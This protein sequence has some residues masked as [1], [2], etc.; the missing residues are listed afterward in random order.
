[1]RTKPDVDTFYSIDR[2]VTINLRV[3]EQEIQGA[4]KTSSSAQNVAFVSQSKSSTNKVKSGFTGAYSTC[5]PSTSSTNIFEKEVLASFADEMD[6]KL[7]LDLAKIAIRMKK[8]YK[9]TGGESSSRNEKHLG[10]T[11]GTS[12][13]HY[14]DPES[15]I[16]SVPPEVYVSTP[17]TTNE[18]ADAR[19]HDS[20]DM[21]TPTPA[22]GFACLIAKATS[23]ESKLWHRRLGHINF[24]NLNK[25][26]KGN[27]VRGLPSKKEEILIELQQEKKASSTD[28][29][30][31]NP[32]IL[33][34]RR[35]LEDIALKHLGKVSENTTT[36]TPSVTS[37]WRNLKKDSRRSTED[38]S[39]GFKPC[40]RRLITS[41]TEQGRNLHISGQVT[42]KT[43]HLN[44][45]KRIF[46]YLKGKPHLGLWYPR[47]SPFDLKAYS[48]ND[49]GGSNLDRKS[50][51][52]GCQILG[53]RLIT[54]QC[55]KQTIVATSTTEADI[56]SYTA[57]CCGQ[58]FG[59]K[60]TTGRW[61][62]FHEITKIHIDNES[63]IC[64][65]KNPM[66]HSKKDKATSR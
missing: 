9:K 50:T 55:K 19:A 17:I 21:K 39:I 20:F 45:V 66:N 6:H 62:Q 34:F 15:E 23:D 5:T 25:L 59:S 52:G 51:T 11:I 48:D 31:D 4:S 46:K 8:F 18:K 28:T 37:N 57:N 53:Q 36:S 30:E 10:K 43:S 61:F 40:Q 44:A 3:F 49:Y 42:P 41:Q 14:V 56:C 60:S 27:L 29:L 22:K 26:V 16:S 12:S 32:K 64:I 35:E 2:L 7:E 65:V 38:E 33:A 58:V 47:E 24:K 54:W 13:E 1:M 63:T